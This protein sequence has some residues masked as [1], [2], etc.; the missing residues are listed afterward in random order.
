MAVES[1]EMG[2]VG[3]EKWPQLSQNRRRKTIV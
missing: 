3:D 2:N 1:G